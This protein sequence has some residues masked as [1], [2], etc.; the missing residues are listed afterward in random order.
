VIAGPSYNYYYYN[1]APQGKGVEEAQ[2]K[3]EEKPPAEPAPE[4]RA[5]R[6]FD[7]AVK[8]FGAGDY[9][10]AK[11]KFH[12]AMQGAPEDVVLPFAY[13]QALF[14]E[15]EYQ[16]ATAILREAMTKVS[17]EQEGVFYPRGLYSDESILQQQIEHLKRAVVLNPA[18]ADFELL[19]GYQLLGISRFEEAGGYLRQAQLDETNRQAAT[20][21]LGVLE[22]LGKVDTDNTES[23]P[24]TSS[25]P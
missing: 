2:Q 15:G 20:V 19:L 23:K 6:D 4:T 10:T 18:H 11:Q 9:T 14:A 24:V 21:L 17:P 25:E 16:E 7:Q 12:D 3:L 22:K 5:D 13:V 1:R 8:A